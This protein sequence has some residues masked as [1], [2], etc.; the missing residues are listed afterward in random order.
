MCMGGVEGSVRSKRIR[1]ERIPILRGKAN[2][3][4][5]RM[6]DPEATEFLSVTILLRGRSG[7]KIRP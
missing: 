3:Y 1:T 4:C 6:Y 5:A 2:V 7:K